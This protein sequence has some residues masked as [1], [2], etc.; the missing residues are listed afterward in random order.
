[1]S[2]IVAIKTG[3]FIVMGSDSLCSNG[4]MKHIRK[5]EKVFKIKNK[6]N[7]EF[8]IGI[9]GSFRLMQIVQYYFTPPKITN[10]DAVKY[11]VVDFVKKLKATFDELDYQMK[12]GERVLVGFEGEIF[13][14]ENDYQVGMPDYNYFAV[15]SGTRY[16]LGSLHTTKDWVLPSNRITVAINSA[17]EFDKSTGGK[18]IIKKLGKLK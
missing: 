16:A 17:K 14:I 9:C 11:I 18:I 15:G 3:N 8:L 10:E 13:C 2:T 12:D 6:D 5:N 4:N 7:K 1:M